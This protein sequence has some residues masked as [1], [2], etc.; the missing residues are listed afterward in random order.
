MKL[1]PLFINAKVFGDVLFVD[2]VFGYNDPGGKALH[3][4]Q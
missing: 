4:H 3:H 1:W 2:S